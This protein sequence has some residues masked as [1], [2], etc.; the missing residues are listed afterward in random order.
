MCTVKKDNRLSHSAGNCLLC[1]TLYKASVC[2]PNINFFFFKLRSNISP[3][4][5]Q[6]RKLEDICCYFALFIGLVLGFVYPVCGLWLPRQLGLMDAPSW[7]TDSS[8]KDSRKKIFVARGVKKYWF[9]NFQHIGK[10]KKKGRFCWKIP[11]NPGIDPFT[12]F[13]RLTTILLNY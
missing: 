8:K 1:T 9:L 6:D 12:L 10:E 2:K 13:F 4:V 5:T 7:I 11:S 3:V